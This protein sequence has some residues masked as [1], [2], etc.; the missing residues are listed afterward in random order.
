LLAGIESFL[1]RPAVLASLKASADM[2][3]KEIRRL[4]FAWTLRSCADDRERFDALRQA[5]T[6]PDIVLAAH[7]LDTA[8]QLEQ[9]VRRSNLAAAACVSVFASIRRRGL[10]LLL[11]ESADSTRSLARAMSFDDSASVRSIAIG[12]LGNDRGEVLRRAHAI[13]ASDGRGSVR[14]VALDVLCVMD[15]QLAP[16]LCQRAT[17]DDAA[18]VRRLAYARLLSATPGAR[19]DEL[20]ARGLADV[21]A[22]VRGVAAACVYR[23][24]SAPPLN[25]LIDY[26][27]RQPGSLNQLVKTAACL[28]PWARLRF[29]LAAVVQASADDARQRVNTALNHWISDASRMFMPPAPADADGIDAVWVMLRDRLPDD[30]RRRLARTLV[31]FKVMV[32][33]EG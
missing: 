15:P 14:S 9:Q 5:V 19:R 10:A 1:C 17:T 7:A 33:D 31:D 29:L 4:L 30:I 32:R 11:R 13:F 18:A 25:T 28:S 24:A 22:L 27:V 12:G 16:D 20:A 26:L 2:G 23:G 6:S 3:S 21:S 8:D